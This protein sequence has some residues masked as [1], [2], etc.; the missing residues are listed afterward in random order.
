[1]KEE[2]LAAIKKKGYRQPTPIQRQVIPVVVSGADVV[3][4]AR[5]G[6]GKTL[7]FVVPMINKLG[8]HSAVRTISPCF[9]IYLE[10]PNICANMNCRVEELFYPLRFWHFRTNAITS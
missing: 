3:A 2:I 9:G 8:K 1:L 4:M 10:D 7:A 6:S 5:T